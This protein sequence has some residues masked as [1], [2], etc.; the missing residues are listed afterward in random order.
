[1]T[2]ILTALLCLGLSVGSRTQ[3]QAGTLPKPTI[4]AEPGSVIPME[5]SVTLWCKG[6]LKA[7]K[8]VLYK[9]GYPET[10]EEQKPLEPKDKA[11]FPITDMT[12]VYAGRYH[13]YYESPTGWSEPSD[14]L[15][16]VVTGMHSKP[17]LSVLPS[18]IVPSGGN[19]TLQ[20][21]SWRGFNRFILMREVEG[22]P[23][24][25]RDSQRAPSGEFQALFP[26]GPVI[27]SLMW[28][29]RCHGFYSNTP[30]V[31][32]LPSDPLE[33]LVSGV[34]GKPSLLTQQGP[35]VTSGQNLTL[36][37]LSDV[38]Y[39]RFAL[40]KEGTSDLLQLHGRQTQ[41]GFSGADFSL[42][43]VKSSRGGQY[44]C[45]GG[46]N[47]SSQW[48]APSD[49]LDIL[50]TG[51]LSYTPSLRVHP[52]PTVAPGENVTLLCQSLSNVDT[53]LLSKDGAAD[54]SLRLRSKYRA[55]KY[56][57]EFS[58][59]PVTP[60]HGGTY[61]CYG[62]IKTSPYLLSYPSV[63]VEILVSGSFG[64]HGPPPTMSSP[65][66]APAQG[67]SWYLYV[68]IGASVAFI[69]MLCLLILLLVRQ[70]RRGKCRKSTGDADPEPKDRGLQD[71]SRPAAVA[72]EET[73]YAAVQ[74]SWPEDGVKLD[75]W[76]N[77]QDEDPQVVTYA[78]VSHSV[79]S[80]KWV[81]ATP[82]SSLSGGLQDSEDRQAEEDR[83]MDSQATASDAPPD[84]TYAQLN[85]LTLRQKTSA[86]SPS[87]SGEPPAEPSVYAALAI[88]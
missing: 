18:P 34:L 21:G 55:G 53:F 37:C 32:S 58:M 68:L 13:C 9:D 16:L 75:H 64:H 2:P 47:L 87:Q 52:G 40:F 19:V 77:T 10:W 69:L 6:S 17:S 30:Q 7:Q 5:T 83:W 8:Y 44:T 25:T 46:H 45:Y 43:P 11:K 84:V 85:H 24:W 81:L 28:T 72:Q 76:Q 41:A 39:D 54:A 57:A 70:Q 67:P 88:H 14:Q 31:W 33:L 26:V 82:L 56:E 73:L 27:P 1:M 74:D 35:V 61:R 60:A 20:C 36:Q 80:L 3:V 23:S 42:S 12:S 50:V 62:S 22:Q 86:S 59:S 71:S 38:S 79:S 15:E 48:S 49:P 66:A 51:Q 65:T 4:W 29:F 63:P 78:Q